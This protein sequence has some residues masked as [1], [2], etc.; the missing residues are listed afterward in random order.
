MLRY[1]G[2]T[3]KVERFEDKDREGKLRWFGPGRWRRSCQ[4]GGQEEDLG[5]DV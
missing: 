3:V 1:L 5:E 4:A 2:G